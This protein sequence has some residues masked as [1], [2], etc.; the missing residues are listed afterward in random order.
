MCTTT[1]RSISVTFLL[2]VSIPAFAA[3]TRKVAMLL[4]G[5]INDQSWNAVGYKGLL[6]LKADGWDTAYSENVQSAD[7]VE[8]LRDYAKRGYDLV[9]G[10]TGRF[11][12]AATRV[13]RDFPQTTFVVGSGSGGAGRNVAS[14]DFDNTQFGY[15]IGVLAAKMSNG[16]QDRILRAGKTDHLAEMAAYLLQPSR[17]GERVMDELA[18]GMVGIPDQQFGPGNG[19]LGCDRS[20]SGFLSHSIPAWPIP[21]RRLPFCSERS[22]REQVASGSAWR[23]DTLDSNRCTNQYSFVIKL[24][25]RDRR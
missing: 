18:E 2:L 21:A 10:H 3:D 8:A 25:S 24:I 17:K 6:K 5:S 22:A 14:V 19:G 23:M 4:P 15:M 20:R 9:I 1:F 12:S 11:L 16:D 7:E 13:G